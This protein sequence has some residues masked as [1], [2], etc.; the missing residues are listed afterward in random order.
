MTLEIVRHAGRWREGVLAFN[1]RMADAGERWGLYVE[2]EDEWLPEREGVPVWRERY[3]AVEN[4][5]YVRGGFILKPQPCWLA[6]ETQTFCDW[7]GP[8]SEGLIEPRHGLVAVRM[9][10]DMIKRQPHLYS[11]G[12]GSG[13]P[14]VL[15]LLAKM[16]FLVHGTPMCV[17]ILRPARFFH[18][19]AWL[20]TSALRRLGLD[21]L[22][23]SGAGF[24]GAHALHGILGLRGRPIRDVTCEEVPGFGEWTDELWERC[25]KHYT[26]VG[27]RDSV[28]MNALLPDGEWPPGTR[29]R[30]RRADE[31]IGFVVVMDTPMT[32]DRRFG[33]LRVGSIVDCFG[34]P[35]DADEVIAAGF[36]FLR[37]RGV[38]LI[39][40]NQ[41]HPAWVR[42]FE[43]SGF[44]A[45]AD[46]RVF[47]AAPALKE[48]LEPLER[49]AAGLHLT[50]M[51]G[52]GPMAL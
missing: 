37:E 17:R 20:R 43:R 48:A 31:T 33:S 47:A 32:D 1:Q 15:D 13:N 24:L 2:P 52:H 9:L 39:V 11:W 28:T 19:N 49:G 40:S 16:G 44:L 29:L 35:E 41:S 23:V 26:L 18:R 3:V 7:L 12:H 14:P 34:A 4:G 21:L 25:K 42:A 6:G 27:A 50:N 45:L 46:R 5:E 38:D 8:I 51:D 22:A 10:R 30:V 36:R